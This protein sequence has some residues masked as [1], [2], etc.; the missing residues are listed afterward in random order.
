[1]KRI[2]LILICYSTLVANSFG[3]NQ[4]D[5]L[6]SSSEPLSLS[7]TLSFKELSNN[8]NDTEYISYQLYYRDSSGNLDSIKIGLRGRGNFRR[9]ECYFLPLA[10]KI[11]KKDAKGTLFEGNKKL[12]LVLPCYE[13]SENN[14][15]VLREFLCYKLYEDVSPYAFHTRLVN[16]AITELR[17][18]RT[19]SFSVKAFLI[20]DL[21]KITA[22]FNAKSFK[23]VQIS[24]PM[25]DTSSLRFDFFEFMISNTDWSKYY[26]HNA[27]II[28]QEP[29]YIPIPY[30]FDM[31]GVVD[32]P[33]ATVSEINGQQ[34]PIAS[35]R[36]RYFR[37]EC[38]N[39]QLTQYI[40]KEFLSKKDK[41]MSRVDGMKG[42]LNDNDITDTKNYLEPFFRILQDDRSFKNEIADMC[43][44]LKN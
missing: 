23:K 11:N 18:K 38:F 22:R 40:R 31:S 27:R 19:K 6:F 35:V 17:G 36:E 3:Q 16:L 2:L 32:A 5:P 30:D 28:Y 42:E 25:H 9:Q 4:T 14:V 24:A 21:D 39:P 13:R 12:K 10:I 26:Q 33:Y 34:L 29:K 20:E 44:P 1:M 7:L 41:F 43:R 8:T 37:G 15:F